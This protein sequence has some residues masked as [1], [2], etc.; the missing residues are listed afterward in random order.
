[1]APGGGGVANVGD[2]P[3]VEQRRFDEDAPGKHGCRGPADR[4]GRLAGLAADARGVGA[5]RRVVRESDEFDRSLEP[6]A[7]RGEK[8]AAS[9]GEVAGLAAANEPGQVPGGQ[10]LPDVPAGVE[11]EEVGGRFQ[12][13]DEIATDVEVVDAGLVSGM[14]GQRRV[15]VAD[16]DRDLLDAAD[17]GEL[18][19]GDRQ[20]R[21]PCL[22][23]RRR[24]RR[25]RGEF[26]AE[27]LHGSHHALAAILT[28]CAGGRA[29]GGEE[30]LGRRGG[31]G[32]GVGGGNGLFVGAVVV[33]GGR[34]GDR[35]RPGE[36]LGIVYAPGER[37]SDHVDKVVD[38]EVPKRDRQQVVAQAGL[39]DHGDLG[40]MPLLGVAPGRDRDRD[41]HEVE[42]VA[43]GVGRVVAL[44]HPPELGQ[45]VEVAGEL[46]E[47]R[48]GL[49]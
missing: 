45:V 38:D 1:M 49:K 11:G 17:V 30:G 15:G 41:P 46:V 24:R 18:R 29:E 6:G 48:C 26:G 12:F 35:L 34:R 23:A 4:R 28:A 14:V 36:A 40:A 44:V 37:R 2:E 7:N 8:P 19:E 21:A 33:A 27:G 22:H 47:V 9:G 32:C 42:R 20:P 3:L 31:A 5:G 39:R 16:Q 13:F 25:D 10:F 43:G